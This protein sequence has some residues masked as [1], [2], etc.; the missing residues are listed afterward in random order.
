[1]ICKCYVGLC[2]IGW[3]H[4]I[5]IEA[6]QKLLRALQVK[7]VVGKAISLYFTA[8]CCLDQIDAALIT[9]MLP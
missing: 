3:L 5:T 6:T 4:I 9:L 1:M 2:Y 7:L 8:V